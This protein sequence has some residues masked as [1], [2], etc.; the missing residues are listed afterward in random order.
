MNVTQITIS[1]CES[2]TSTKSEGK[3]E[4]TAEEFETDEIKKN[5]EQILFL[6][7]NYFH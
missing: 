5:V 4:R 3:C 2:K 6:R 7:C 1:V